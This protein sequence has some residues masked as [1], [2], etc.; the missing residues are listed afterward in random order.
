MDINDRYDLKTYFSKRF[1]KTFIP[2]IIWSFIGLAFQIFY[3]KT[4]KIGDV[5]LNYILNG[6]INGNLTNVYWFFIPLFCTYL[7][8]PL[9]SLV[10]EDKR[11]E[12]FTY[13]TTLGFVLNI[14]IPFIIS[15]F[16]LKIE[17]GITLAASSGYL[18]FTLTG[19]LL[20]KYELKRK[21]KT[22][23]Y[24]LA[25]ICLG[26]HI[27]G[28]YNLSIA[29]GEI[30]TTYKGYNNIPCAL[31]SLGVFVFIKYELIKL[32]KI[33]F[34]N[35]TVNFLNNYTFGFYLIHWYIIAILIKTFNLPKF[36]IVQDWSTICD[37]NNFCWNNMD[38]SENTYS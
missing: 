15:V 24:L 35:K 23:L 10:P 11:K 9:F 5:N 2:F 1:T 16:N 36:S 6:L 14:L 4:V 26:M 28:T 18:F 17:W 8:I 3:L 33:D 20:H 13:L 34:I 21:Y 29:A 19:Y 37:F 12:I 31:Y 30:I 38:Y 27:I 25:V 22:I 32:M 7:A